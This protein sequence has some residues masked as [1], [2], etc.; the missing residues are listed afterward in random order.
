M[1]HMQVF[2]NSEFGSV[3]TLEE[4]GMILFCAKDIA[5]NLGYGNT[6]TR[7]KDIVRGS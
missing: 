3:R 5:I 6:G 7:F 1:D 2:K 4:N